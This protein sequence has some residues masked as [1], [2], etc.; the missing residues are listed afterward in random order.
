VAGPVSTEHFLGRCAGGPPGAVDPPTNAR[1]GGGGGGGEE[2]AMCGRGAPRAGPTR[3]SLG[4]WPRR[5]ARAR[6]ARGRTG[7]DVSRRGAHGERRGKAGRPPAARHRGHT[8]LAGRRVCAR[9]SPLPPRA[10]PPPAV[11]HPRSGLRT[12]GR[13]RRRREGG[14]A[15]QRHTGAGRGRVRR[16]VGAGRAAAA[17]G[18]GAAA[19]CGC[20]RAAF[21]RSRQHAGQKAGLGHAPPAQSCHKPASSER[22]CA[23]EAAAA[24]EG[25]RRVQVGRPPQPRARG[26][27]RL[28]REA[29]Q[30]RH[31]IQRLTGRKSEKE[32]GRTHTHRKG[33]EV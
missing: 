28:G 31:G 27:A 8:R 10:A 17:S 13:E 33:L 2:E 16:R 6:T 20:A 3:A 12:R 5:G 11:L 1:G 14:G 7:W 22:V 32:K 30:E 29:R 15:G 21:P 25:G 9:P 26:R 23:L 18:C 4:P 24:G 19:H